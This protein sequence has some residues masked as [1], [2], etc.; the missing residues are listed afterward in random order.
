MNTGYNPTLPGTP[1]LAVVWSNAD[2]LASVA[3]MLPLDISLVLSLSRSV[4][5]TVCQNNGIVEER[6]DAVD[7]LIE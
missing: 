3:Q 1:V 7:C 6:Y 2:K 4:Y 5:L